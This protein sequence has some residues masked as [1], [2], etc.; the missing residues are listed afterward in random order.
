MSGTSSSAGFSRRRLLQLGAGG[1]GL[2]VAGSLLPPSVHEAL[3]SPPPRGGLR[4]IKHV[5]VL[6]Q[7]NRS[8]DHYYGSLRGVRGFGDRAAVRLRDGKSV[9]EQPG[10]PAGRVLPFSVREAARAAS[11]DL[12]YIGDLDHSWTGGHKAWADGWYD[13]WIGAKTPATMAFYDRTDLP[14]HYELADTF[15]ICDAYHCAVPTSTSPNRNYLV[16]GYTGYEPGSTTVRA[17]TNSAYAEDTHAGYSWTTYAELLERA[18]RSW[19]VYQEWDNYQDNNLEFYAEFKRIARKALAPAG[20]FRSL[21]S[22]YAQVFRLPA[23][24]Q[25]ALLAKLEQ[26]VAAL[27]PAERSL[28]ERALRRVRP[29]CLAAD[30]RADVEAGRL[31]EV[32]YLVPSAADSEHPGASSPAAS[33]TITYQ[34]LDA[35]ASNREVWDST[36]LFIT[37]DENDGFFD[38]V[39]PPCP[40]DEVAD[41]FYGGW[42]IGFGARVPMTVVSPWTVG[43]YVSSEVFDHTSVTR[44]LETWTG[45][46]APD[47]SAWRRRV[48]GDLTGV[49]DFDRAR[50]PGLPARPAPAPVFTGRWRPTPPAEQRLPEQEPGRRRARALP[51]QPDASLTVRPE[52]RTLVLRLANEGRSSAHL[53]LF[54]YSGEFAKPRHFDVRDTRREEIAAAANR[55]D[56][57]VLGPNGF[58]RDFAG[59]VAGPAAGAEVTSRVRGTWRIL[60]ITLVNRG[61]EPLTF[62]LAANAYADGPAEDERTVTLKPGRERTVRWTTGRS[63]GWYDVAVTVDGPGDFRRRLAGHIE[64]GRESVSG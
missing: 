31:P 62:R 47:I 58:R 21:D 43:G 23:P 36:A 18:G 55:Y 33:A 16:S 25:D 17:V 39:P 12:Q 38:H 52:S 15:T 22:F 51:Y 60:E 2:A 8:F 41:E 50:R 46:R 42:P 61:S 64:N 6:V 59:P 5:V 45:V 24:E 53:T 27:T 3:A 14:F 44:F 4:A 11:K 20:S 29:H 28:Y 40:P 56:L 9:F 13:G 48:S 26:G 63:E 19:K 37:F 10:G 32:S 49:F 54:P 30:F 7:E 1:A 34:I 57:A 35:I